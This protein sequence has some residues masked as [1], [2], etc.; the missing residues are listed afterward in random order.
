MAPKGSL[1]C[2]QQP[3]S[4]PHP[5]PHE[6][7][8]H[9]PNAKGYSIKVRHADT[10]GEFIIGAYGRNVMLDSTEKVGL[11]RDRFSLW[12]FNDVNLTRCKIN[13]MT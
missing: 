8:L 4:G 6:S 3:G 12:L 9:N 13:V 2:S 5:K 10:P 1:T 7:N 11:I